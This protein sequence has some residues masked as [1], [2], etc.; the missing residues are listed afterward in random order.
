MHQFEI[1]AK[2]TEESSL[3]RDVLVIDFNPQ[4]LEELR[5]RGVRCVYG[6]IASMDTLQHA[7]STAP[8]S[9]SAR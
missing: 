7:S 9:S 3:L 4:V 5:R 6:D 8:G 1:E 2:A